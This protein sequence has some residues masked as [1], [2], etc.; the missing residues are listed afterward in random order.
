[1][2]ASRKFRILEVRNG[3]LLRLQW[4]LIPLFP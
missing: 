1:M 2:W 4:N 3:H